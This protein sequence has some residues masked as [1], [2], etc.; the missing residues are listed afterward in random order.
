MLIGDDSGITKP[1]YFG[2]VIYGFHC[3]K[4][5]SDMTLRAFE[6]NDFSEGFLKAYE[7]G[8]KGVIGKSIKFGL[9]GRAV[10]KKMNNKQIDLLFSKFENS[11]FLNKMDMDFPSFS[12]FG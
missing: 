12:V 5:A 8:W 11:R 10:F 2:G 6:K 9:I 4:I 1:W 3:A 7:K